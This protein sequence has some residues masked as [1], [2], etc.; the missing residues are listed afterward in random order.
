MGFLSFVLLMSC[1]T[2]PGTENVLPPPASLDEGIRAQGSVIFRSWNGRWRGTD[3]D[4]DIQFLP[5]NKVKVI[6]YGEGVETYRGTYRLS[7]DGDVTVSLEGYRGSCPAM[8][9]RRD[10]R[11]FFL[12]PKNPEAKPAIRDRFT[13]LS[14]ISPGFWPFRHIPKQEGSRFH[15]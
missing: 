4:T 14:E 15:D 3:I 9:L 5:A 13:V 7:E 1:S 10:A 2:P 12:L 6:E 8:V 11:S